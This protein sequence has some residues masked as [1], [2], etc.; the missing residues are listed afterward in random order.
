MKILCL[1]GY[2]DF[3]KR[4][5]NALSIVQKKKKLKID[6]L[7]FGKHNYEFLVNQKK[8]KYNKI[9]LVEKIF[10]RLEKKFK[11]KNNN[12]YLNKLIDLEKKINIDTNSLI[13]SE[14]IFATHTHFNN[15][16]IK[17]SHEKICFTVY[18]ILKIMINLFKSNY[19]FCYV[20]ASASLFSEI[21]FSLAKFKKIKCFTVDH[22]RLFNFYITFE[23]N[24]EYPEEVMMHYK[25]KDIGYKKQNIKQLYNKYLNSIKQTNDPK[26]ILKRHNSLRQ[27]QKRINFKNIIR[28]LKLFFFDTDRKHYLSPSKY[29]RLK[30]NFLY[31]Y[32]EFF[33]DKFVNNQLPNT[34][35]VYYPLSTIPEASLLIR[36]KDYYDQ[37]GVIKKISL[38][39]PVNFKLVVKD[40]PGMIGVTPISFYEELN[41]IYNVHLIHTLYPNYKCISNSEANIVVSGTTGM[42]S[43]FL[44]KK[45]IILGDAVYSYLSST[46]NIKN[47]N[48]IKNILNLQWGNKEK[49]LQ[50]NDVLKYI[51]AIIKSK[52]INDQDG[53]YWSQST[54]PNTNELKIDE[55]MSKIFLNYLN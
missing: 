53:Q 52:K 33:Y 16:R 20:Y 1:T 37:L 54:I 25:S 49:K 29:Q 48:E 55:E 10:E 35:Y 18:E 31:K 5:N 22:S 36:G 38:L 39:L 26:N 34:K 17:M 14:R 3:T 51:N 13:Y 15:Y 43:L 44:G 2:G 46:F 23:N 42:E 41:K 11:F 24:K 12:K 28:F 8:T 50:K 7:V 45:T 40:H 4:T 27:N 9:L 32:N 47:L 19:K 6:I 30:N 21:I